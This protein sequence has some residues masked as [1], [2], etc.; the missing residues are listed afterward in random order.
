MSIDLKALCAEHCGSAHPD[1]IAQN[2]PL[3][4]AVASAVLS[5][6][7]SRQWTLISKSKFDPGNATRVIKELKRELCGD[8][9]E[10]S[11]S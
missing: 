8:E 10:R 3:A 1:D 11:K 7:R 5:E 6:V 9:Q 2:M 4:C